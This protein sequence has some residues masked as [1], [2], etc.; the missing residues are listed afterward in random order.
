VRIG[1]SLEGSDCDTHSAAA[2]QNAAASQTPLDVEDL[3]AIE[4]SVA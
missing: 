2:L 1:Y 3:P 4:P